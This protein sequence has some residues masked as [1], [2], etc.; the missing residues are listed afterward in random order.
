M[1]RKS[2]TETGIYIDQVD[3]RVYN[4]YKQHNRWYIDLP[5][6]LEQGGSKNDL[7]MVAGAD[8][9]LDIMARGRKKLSLE[10]DRELFA[11]ADLL[12]LDELCEAPMGGGYYIL[13]TYGGKEINK[14]MWLCDV[15]LFVFGDMPE[16]I[17]IKKLDNRL[18]DKN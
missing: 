1:F 18:P 2:T 8:E 11:D 12:Q 15:V 10:M 16:K 5:E 7:E 6:Y 14:R 4:F 9:M 3:R 13:H 17:F